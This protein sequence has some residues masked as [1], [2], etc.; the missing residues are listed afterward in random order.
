MSPSQIAELLRQNPQLQSLVRGRITGSG[1]QLQDVRNQLAG[2]G[3][4]TDLLDAFLEGRN[5]D[6]AFF[7]TNTLRAISL[8]GVNA[9]GIPDSLL[10]PPDTTAWRMGAD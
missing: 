9:F 2:T 4:S 3:F 1:L 7:N 8:L 6:P 10:M 5:V